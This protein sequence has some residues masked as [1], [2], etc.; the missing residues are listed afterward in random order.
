MKLPT[1]AL[2][3]P[4][5]LTGCV[6]DVDS[7]GQI[8]R[9]E[10]RFAVSGVPDLRLSTFD[11][12]IE[13][14]SWERPDVLVE[15]E[16]RGPTREAVDALEIE[17]TQDA[18]RIALEVKQPRRENFSGFGFNQSVNARLIVSVPQR[19]DVVART[20][21]GSIRIDRLAGRIELRT[22]DGS[23]RASEV[24]GELKMNTGDGAINVEGA[25][26]QL[27]LET[28][29]GG[30]AVTGKLTAL[31]MHTGDGSIAYHAA[32]GSSMEDDWTIST[33]DGTVS[34]YLPSDFNAEI[35]AH[36]GDGS[37]SNE[38]KLTSGSGADRRSVRG[39]LGSGGRLLR[40]RTGDGSIRLRTN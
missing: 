28:G 32:P 35:D 38:L 39:R 31:R 13:I 23:I 15:I 19:C 27:D 26:G 7:Q 29:D 37:V 12:S 2:L 25:E 5:A 4:L 21:D 33:G 3:A 9:D 8:V 30:V 17:T 34:L 11:G 40:V 6:V 24:S 36:T 10:K 16:K 20:G 14:R 18:N 1:L 22:G